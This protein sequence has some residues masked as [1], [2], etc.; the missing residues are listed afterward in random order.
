ML[1]FA[2]ALV[3][4]GIGRMRQIRHGT[5]VNKAANKQQAY[6]LGAARAETARKLKEKYA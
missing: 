5:A 3:Q 2:L 6:F 4:F 1:A